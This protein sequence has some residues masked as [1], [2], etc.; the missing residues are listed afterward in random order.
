MLIQTDVASLTGF[1]Q[2]YYLMAV[3]STVEI[4]V[5]YDRL[6]ML[7]LGFVVNIVIVLILKGSFRM[8]LDGQS[9]LTQIVCSRVN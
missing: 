9:H 7:R 4:I 2:F 1:V 6:C 5:M 8:C 3:E